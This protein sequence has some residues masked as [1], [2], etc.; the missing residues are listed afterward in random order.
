MSSEEK[1]SEDDK[2]VTAAD[3]FVRADVMMA[4]EIPIVPLKDPAVCTPPRHQQ[5]PRICEYPCGPCA[6]MQ[7][8]WGTL[9]GA[10]IPWEVIGCH[11]ISRGPRKAPRSR[12]GTPGATQGTARPMQS[13]G[14]ALARRKGYFKIWGRSWI[15]IPV[16]HILV[17][18]NMYCRMAL[19]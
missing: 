9:G 1:Q 17:N 16:R 10:R 4:D 13:S 8:P 15:V 7:D 12:Q 5:K 18:R 2:V 3:E 6:P 11:A 19:V 14:S